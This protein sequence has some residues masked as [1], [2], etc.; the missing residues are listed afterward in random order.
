M[1]SIVKYV[2]PKLAFKLLRI[3][4]LLRQLSK[5]AATME[6]I[7]RWSAGAQCLPETAVNL[8]EKDDLKTIASELK[9]RLKELSFGSSKSKKKSGKR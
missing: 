3:L 5:R 8:I 2:E 1:G 4:S 7:E 9:K 6:E